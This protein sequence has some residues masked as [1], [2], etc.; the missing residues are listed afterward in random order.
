M[1]RDKQIHP[2][3]RQPVRRRLL[4][5]WVMLLVLVA[6]I[7]TCLPV[8]AADMPADLA[9]YAP[10]DCAAYLTIDMR[11]VIEQREAFAPTIAAWQ[12]SH[13]ATQLRAGLLQELGA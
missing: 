8:L 12:N 4:S 11:P 10:A 13:F 3:H 9:A 6:V 2:L 5:G 7:C 1:Q